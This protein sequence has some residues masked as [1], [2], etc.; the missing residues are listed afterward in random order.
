MNESKHPKYPIL[1]VD[2]EIN[3]LN[4]FELTLV[5][6]GLDN[7]ILCSDSRNVIKL[8]TEHPISLI[9]LDLSMPHIRGA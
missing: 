5:E 9:L 8:L 6:H 4:S 7:S 1:I 3:L 2:D